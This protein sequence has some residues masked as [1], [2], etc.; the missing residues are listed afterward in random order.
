MSRPVTAREA[1]LRG[2]D[3]SS[4]DPNGGPVAEKH[5]V[6]NPAMKAVVGEGVGRVIT[7]FEARVAPEDIEE[8]VLVS[9]IE[10]KAAAP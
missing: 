9:D 3:R 7:E 5:P 6:P 4:F 10:G 2:V 1:G 8:I